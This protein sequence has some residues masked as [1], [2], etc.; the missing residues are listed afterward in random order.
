MATTGRSTGIIRLSHT[1]AMASMGI[2]AGFHLTGDALV[3]QSATVTDGNGNWIYHT[4]NAAT[5]PP[6]PFMLPK[7]KRFDSLSCSALGA[8]TY[9]MIYLK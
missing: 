3:A 8:G 2:V 7:A 6:G 5:A 1:D 4:A 9:M